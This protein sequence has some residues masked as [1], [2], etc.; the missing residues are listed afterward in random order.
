M[1][2]NLKKFVI[3]CPFVTFVILFVA[4]A[5]SFAVTGD[6]I[7]GDGSGGGG[8][9]SYT[10][11]NP[12]GAGGAGGASDDTLNGTAG[13]DIIFGDGSGGGAGGRSSGYGYL[14]MGG[15]AGSG[16]DTISGAA[17]D[18]IIFGD[19]FSGKDC[20]FS[21][22]AGG[23][24]GG[25]GGGGGGDYSSG[26]A[27]GLSGLGAGGGGGGGSIGNPSGGSVL[28]SDFGNPGFDNDS[29][30]DGGESATAIRKW[31]NNPMIAS[32]GT[33]L[34]TSGGGG[35]GGFGG[36]NGGDSDSQGADGVDGTDGSDAVFTFSD[37]TGAIRSYFTDAVL[38]GVYT[39]YSDFGHG[40]DTL[41]GGAGSDELF[42]LGGPDTFIVE[43]T[44]HPESD[45]ARDRIWD[46]LPGDVL[47]L[48]AGGSNLPAV[49]LNT[50]SSTASSMVDADA[51]GLEDDLRIVFTHSSYPDY[52]V[53]VD[54]INISSVGMANTGGEFVSPN[55]TPQI[56]LADTKLTYEGSDP[57]V[58]IDSDATISDAD[59]DSAW[60]NAKLTI[61]ITNG[62]D[63]NDEISIGDAPE[64]LTL[65][66]DGYF[67]RATGTT[68]DGVSLGTD[69]KSIATLSAI[70][71][72]VSDSTALTV[73]FDSTATEAIV[74]EVL[75]S[76]QY[77]STAEGNRTILV[78]VSD[79]G[80]AS[81]SD[82]RTVNYNNSAP[83]LS[84]PDPANYTN[85]TSVS[86]SFSDDTG[87]LSATDNDPGDTLTYGIAEGSISGG[88]ISKSGQYG[89]LTV[90][91]ATGAYTYSP[92]DDV[93]NSLS[94][95]AADTF[96]VTVD[97]GA[98][99]DSQIYSVNITTVYSEMNVQASGTAIAD[100]DT[101]PSVSDDTD[102]GNADILTGTVEKIFTIENLGTG[103]LSLSGSP[104]V[105]ITGDNAADF[106]VTTSPDTTVPA[107]STTTTF[108]VSF[109]P[110][111]A[112]L[113]TAT[114]SIANNDS[115][116]NPYNFSIQGT[117]TSTPE[118][119]IQGSGTSITDGDT[120]PSVSDNTDF[121]SAD[122]MT[123][124]VEK[125][126]TIKNLGSGTITLSGSTIVVVD[127]A[128][129]AD[130]SVTINPVATV[131][132]GSSTS[133]VVSFDPSGVGL[134]TA[135][136]S[137]ANNDGD[138]NPYN[139]S[140]QGTGTKEPEIN[141]QGSGADIIDGDTTPS[142]SDDTDFGSADILAGFVNKIFKIQNLGSSTLNLTGS[143]I[144]TVSGTNADDF[145]VTSSPDS[146]LAASG[147]T[148]F[149]VRFD[150]TAAGLRTATVSIANNDS[151]EN[152]YNFS[153]QG[154]GTEEPEI[155]VQGNSVTIDDGDTTASVS[156]H[157]DFGS[158]D[159]TAGTV[160][161]TFTI[162]N[163]G[164]SSLTLSGSPLV[165][166]GGTN[167]ADFSIVS[168]PASQIASGGSA[169]FTVRFD[170]SQSGQ[171]TA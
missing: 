155:D 161:R 28:V 163:L 45:N 66:V 63:S 40:A 127:G 171:R 81:S 13:D 38:S 149:T 91:M 134:R 24:G 151:N 129:A 123:G 125:I 156:D 145:S 104:P 164:S 108:T 112:G 158:T 107:G 14:T 147:D 150:P 95:N 2:R 117:G 43:L 80:H 137:I 12:G 99:T 170:P 128:N 109:D 61:Q 74:E 4:A 27:G 36:A 115:D 84:A 130:F 10:A 119:D 77:Y 8:G 90:T 54:L 42:G 162:E 133:Y 71:G 3:L 124:T 105:S 166:V 148:T 97:D 136:L 32:G 47:I 37:T 144:V 75:Q 116:E 50:L 15:I 87:V 65:E 89:D 76:F 106:S 113:R 52:S 154:M 9:G 31:D 39:N 19:G 44:D 78:T 93:I 92:D 118:I 5:A 168:N 153:I 48:K 114:L 41:N 17:G 135:T 57:A 18:D 102:F 142:L 26:P 35:G 70:N 122:I 79:S 103:V 82:S 72:V 139:F 46:F 59:G 23:L 6:F 25:G 21:P 140:I 51:D 29:G 159:I 152:P 165:A 88:S 101:S 53:K 143:P 131:A 49:T 34:S 157:T 16:D 96:T 160:D 83:N 55:N 126:F 85:H 1:N 58:F 64:N 67:L 141:V 132:V 98:V 121:G 167:S 120:T 60:K 62:A 33:R 169:T 20:D 146:A 138:E 111:E 7:T 22:G 69:L 110:S 11:N 68:S 30:G 73:T 86:E 56:S 94:G 100:G